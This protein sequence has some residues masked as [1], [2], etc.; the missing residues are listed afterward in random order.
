[1]HAI[2]PSPRFDIDAWH[3]VYGDRFVFHSALSLDALLGD[4]GDDTLSGGLDNDSLDGGLG[5]DTLLGDDDDD[6]NGYT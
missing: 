6:P 5:L 1:M 4:D 3:K 2:D